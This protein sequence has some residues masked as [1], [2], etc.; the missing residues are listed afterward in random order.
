[1]LTF[2]KP[3]GLDRSVIVLLH[4]LICLPVTVFRKNCRFDLSKA[5]RLYSSA[6]PAGSNAGAVTM[7]SSRQAGQMNRKVRRGCIQL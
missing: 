1:M 2:L 3:L 6:L 4:P 7:V 5:C